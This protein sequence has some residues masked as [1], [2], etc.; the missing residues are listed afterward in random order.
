[1]ALKTAV[2]LANLSVRLILSYV[3]FCL[4]LLFFGVFLLR[5][6]LQIGVYV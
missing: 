1:M 2:L 4:G 5:A 3:S 6:F